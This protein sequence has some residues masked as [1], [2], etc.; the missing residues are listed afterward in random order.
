MLRSSSLRPLVVSRSSMAILLGL[1][2]FV[3]LAAVGFATVASVDRAGRAREQARAALV[4]ST[5]LLAAVVDIETGQR[6]YVLSGDPGYLE[7]YTDALQRYP[8]LL[9]QL[10]RDV[11]GI[12]PAEPSLVGL[13][14]L[15]EQRVAIA[16][17]AVAIRRTAGADA[18]RRAMEVH[19]GRDLTQ[20]LR[21]RIAHLDAQLEATIARWDAQ[22]SRV[23]RE[24]R[25]TAGGLALLGTLVILASIV[26]LEREHARRA[27][28]ELALQEANARLEVRVGERTAELEQARRQLQTFA[29]RL[30]RQVEGERRRLAREV[31]DQLGQVFTALKL[32]LSH[33]AARHPQAAEPLGQAIALLDEGVITARRIASELRPPLLDDLGLAAAI[34]HRGQRFQDETGVACEV[35]VVDAEGLNAEQSLQLFRIVQESLTNV[36]RHA[37]AS[38]VRIEGCV[39]GM[40][41]RLGVADNG[42]G[43]AEPRPSSLGMLSILERTLLSG[44]VLTVDSVPGQGTR[45]EVRLPLQAQG[46]A[47]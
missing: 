35:D 3:L 6:G 39:D 19:H 44:G 27:R 36:A 30:D 2:L 32:T 7:P 8:A 47:A 13:D 4:S 5:R 46:E 45:I 41:Y 23:Q 28:A 24:A 29:R 17:D 15:V 31:H 43:M 42:R 22:A 33:A 10:H 18:A 25:W 38:K 37:A 14:A 21:R 1:T 11:A 40:Q 20:A 26:V 34:E 12:A 16:R 9:A